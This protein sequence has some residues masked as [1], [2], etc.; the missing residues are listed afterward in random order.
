MEEALHGV[1]A[2]DDHQR[3]AEEEVEAHQQQ[4]DVGCFYTAAHSLLEEY[5]RQLGVG[6]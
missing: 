3:H 6:Q 5:T 2:H 4:Q 1:H